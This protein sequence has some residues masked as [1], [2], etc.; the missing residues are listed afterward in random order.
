MVGLSQVMWKCASAML[1]AAKYPEERIGIGLLLIR[2]DKD[3][4][5]MHI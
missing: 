2:G 3:G 5:G 1:S 4:A